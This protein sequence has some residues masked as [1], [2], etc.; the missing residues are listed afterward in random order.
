MLHSAGIALTFLFCV[1]S[2]SAEENSWEK[3]KPQAT[4]SLLAEKEAV[5]GS[6]LHRIA[7]GFNS[8]EPFTFVQ[9]GANVAATS[10]DPLYPAP[11]LKKNWRGVLLEPLPDYYDE[12]RRNYNYRAPSVSAE[13]HPCTL[14][15]WG[16]NC[17]G[18]LRLKT[19]RYVRPQNRRRCSDRVRA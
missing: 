17:A 18:T 1:A 5:L 14:I 9:I 6:L 2:G 3:H 8:T 15:A 16:H 12:L 11:L 7:T 19:S 4:N 13:A 10:N